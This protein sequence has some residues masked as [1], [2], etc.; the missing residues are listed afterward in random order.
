MYYTDNTDWFTYNNNSFTPVFSDDVENWIWS[1]T[2]F[3]TQAYDLCG[4]DAE[5]LYDVFVTG[6]LAIGESSKQTAADSAATTAAL[7]MSS[8]A[9]LGMFGTELPKRGVA[10]GSPGHWLSELG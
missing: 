5:C 10:A 2:G 9:I 1:S 8:A 4:D 7:S 6:D 3:K